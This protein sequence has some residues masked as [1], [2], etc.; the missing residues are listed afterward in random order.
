M[1]RLLV[2]IVGIQVLILGLMAFHMSQLQ[3]TEYDAI[4]SEQLL[5]GIRTIVREE[6]EGGLLQVG[7]VPAEAETSLGFDDPVQ[8]EEEYTALMEVNQA[9]ELHISRGSTSREALAELETHLFELSPSGRKA[10]LR[11]FA[12]AVNSGELAGRL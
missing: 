3:D 7:P 2:T 10:A 11:R 8:T 5:T 4:D 6:L 9:L 1:I 12:H